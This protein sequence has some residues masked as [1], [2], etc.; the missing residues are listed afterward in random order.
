MVDNFA[1]FET[2]LPFDKGEKYLVYLHRRGKE[3]PELTD[4]TV[5]YGNPDVLK[6]WWLIGSAAELEALRETLIE[7]SREYNARVCLKPNRVV[8]EDLKDET[9]T[10]ML[11]T[12]RLGENLYIIDCDETDRANIP[13]IK[14][15]IWQSPWGADALRYEV[16]TPN[17]VHLITDTFH[18]GT[19]RE[20]FP[21]VHIRTSRG[22]VLYYDKKTNK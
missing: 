21:S 6:G 5:D 3:N 22:T 20:R 15:I 12:Q 14:E 2:L 8:V 13:A 11:R 18:L 1:Y 17:G 7:K 4:D 9:F 19:L 16:P 10:S